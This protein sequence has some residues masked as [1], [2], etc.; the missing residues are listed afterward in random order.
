MFQ[1][2]SLVDFLVQSP[3]NAFLESCWNGE[4]YLNFPVKEGNDAYDTGGTNPHALFFLIYIEKLKLP[5]AKPGRAAKLALWLAKQVRDDGYCL[6]QQGFTDHPAHA[7]TLGDALATAAY[8]GEVI[9]LA[10]ND[11]DQVVA[12]VKRIID[13]H[14]RIR[15]PEGAQG[16]TQQLRFELRMY[17]WMM[18]LSK[19]AI[20]RE[21]FTVALN[22]GIYRYTHQ[23][24]IDGPIVQPS[25]NPDWTWNYISTGGLIKEHSTNTHTPA[26]YAT[27]PNGFM[28]VYLHAIKNQTFARRADFDEFCRKYIAGMLKNMSRAGH[29]AS[30]L[31]GYGIHRAWYGPVL[32]EGIPLECAALADVLGE[33]ELAGFMRYYIDRYL[34]FVKRC[35]T[36]AASGLPPAQPY[37]HKINIEAQFSQLASIRFYGSIARAL[38]EFGHVDAIKAVEPPM[39]GTYSWFAQWLRVSTPAYETSFAAYSCLRNIPVV[40]CYGDPNLGTLIGGSPLATLQSTTDLVY[41]ASFPAD[42]LWHIEVDDHNGRR[43]RSCSTSPRDHYQMAVRHSNGN[44][45][46]DTD[47]VEYE[48]PCN[49]WVGPGEYLELDYQRD[50]PGYEF[51]FF[52]HNIYRQNDL[53]LVFGV[54]GKAGHYFDKVSFV[55]PIPDRE[56]KVSADGQTFVPIDQ[57]Q[58]GKLCAVC[59]QIG[60]T[61]TVIDQLDAN[62]AY[63]LCNR[64]LPDTVNMPGAVNAFSPYRTRQLRL[65]AVHDVKATLWKLKARVHFQKI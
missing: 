17:Y 63:T 26:Y 31:D 57:Y 16:I 44:I 13:N 62:F 25:L 41:A 1:H 32:C 27:E 9:G 42:S 54:R 5:N 39:Y 14:H 15:F 28:F 18:L 34:D 12:A 35:D 43:F 21:R 60:D 45:L 51:K 24:A 38:A 19:D 61:V 29:L 30:D 33:N 53:E 47:F 48:S 56:L 65:E 55:L 4:Y 6:T 36:F 10:G 52:V 50:E 7:S 22:N 3:V 46:T 40:P 8:Y 20:W 37:G 58:G 2:Y 11:R 64:E 49:L 23:V 59:W